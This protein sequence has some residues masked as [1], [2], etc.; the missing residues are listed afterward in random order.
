M[1]E[2]K[3]NDWIFSIIDNPNMTV[4]SFESVGLSSKN[5]S[6]ETEDKYKQVNEI[7]NHPMFQTNGA[8]DEGKFHQFYQNSLAGYSQLANDTFQDDLASA[9]SYYKD[10]IFA[11]TQRPEQMNK[12]LEAETSLLK[13]ANPFKHQI[14][15]QGLGSMVTSP[16]STSE[17]AQTHNILSNPE[18]VDFIKGDFSKAKWIESPNELAL[19]SNPVGYF[20]NLGNTQ[21]LAEWDNDGEHYDPLTHTTVQHKK[22]DFKYDENGNIF[23][24]NLNGRNIYGKKVLSKWDT[25]TVDGTSINSYDFF[26]SDDKQK[27]VKGTLLRSIFEVAPMFIPYV[28]TA[29]VGTRIAL[30]LSNLMATVGKMA[31]ES[32][33]LEVPFLADV[34][35][36][37]K[38][39]EFSTSEYSQNK[40]W[41]WENMINMATDVVTQLVEQRRMFEAI[42]KLQYMRKDALSEKHIGELRKGFMEEFMETNKAKGLEEFLTNPKLAQ[43]YADIKIKELT[44]VARSFGGELSRVYMTGITVADTYGDAIANGATP[45]EAALLTLGYAAGEYGILKTDIGNWILP[46]LK[47]EKQNMKQIVKTALAGPKL[48][49]ASNVAEKLSIGQRLLNFG[50]KV[51]QADYSG[52]KMTGEAVIANAL[53]EG[54]EETSEELLS[55]I[56]KQLG[57]WTI[58]PLFG[59]NTDFKPWEDISTRYAQSFLGG[60]LGGAVGQ[61]DPSYIAQTHAMTN[62]TYDQAIQQSVYLIGEGKGE[63]L[64]K[65]ASKLPLNNSYVSGLDQSERSLAAG[66]NSP[67][68][69]DQASKQMFNNFVD[70]TQDIL[71]SHGASIKAGTVLERNSDFLKKLR[72]EELANIHRGIKPEGSNTEQVSLT[73]Y[74]SFLQDFNTAR[75]ELVKKEFALK[76]LLHT[77]AIDSQKKEAAK[78]LDPAK[79]AQ[80]RLDVTKAAEEV[81]KYLEGKKTPE[82]VRFAIKEMSPIYM[83]PFE[84]VNEVI[85]VESYFGT[86]YDKLTPEQKSEGTVKWEEYKNSGVHKDRMRIAD[87]M[88]HKIAQML[89]PVLDDIQTNYFDKLDDDRFRI[90]QNVM[91]FQSRNLKSISD[92]ETLM[93]ALSKNPNFTPEVFD[94]QQEFFQRASAFTGV[95][96]EG[97]YQEQLSVDNPMHRLVAELA[98]FDPTI[99]VKIESLQDMIEKGQK[100]L[101]EAVKDYSNIVGESIYTN[102]DKIFTP[103]IS[104]GF[105]HP[106]MKPLALQALNNSIAYYE[107]MEIDKNTD[108]EGYNKQQ[109]ILTELKDTKREIQKLGSVPMLQILD[110]F[111]LSISEPTMTISQLMEQL[112]KLLEAPALSTVSIPKNLSTAIQQAEKVLQIYDSQLLGATTDEVGTINQDGNIGLDLFGV[113]ATVNQLE[114]KYGIPMEE[115]SNL[116]ELKGQ[117]A[118]QLREELKPIFNKIQFLRKLTELNSG[119]RISEQA[120]TAARAYHTMFSKFK[121]KL[122]GHDDL[123]DDTWNTDKDESGQGAL[124]RLKAAL[125]GL[126]ILNEMKAGEY[127]FEKEDR[128]KLEQ[129]RVKFEDAIYDFFQA[130][131]KKSYKDRAKVF[132][133]LNFADPENQLL[134]GD[135]GELSDAH[136][137]YWLMSRAVMKS[138]EFLNEYKNAFGNNSRIAPVV[139]QELGVHLAYATILKGDKMASWTKALADVIAEK[140]GNVPTYLDGIE[141][142]IGSSTDPYETSITP[143]FLRTV[144]IEGVPGS[145]KST[146]VASTIVAMLKA[147]HNDTLLKNVWVAHIGSDEA[148]ALSQDIGLEGAQVFDRTELLKLITGNTYDVDALKYTEDG[149]VDYGILPKRD[150]YYKMPMDYVDLEASKIP[151]II[152]ID[153]IG[154]FTSMELDMLDDFATK[155]GITVV[156]LGDLD[157]KKTI[158][159]GYSSQEQVD[160]ND[161]DLNEQLFR[162]NFIHAPKLGLS[163]RAD[164]NLKQDNQKWFQSSFDLLYNLKFSNETEFG[165]GVLK[166]FMDGGHPKLTFKYFENETGLFGERLINE[167]PGTSELSED[168]KES[169]VNMLRSRKPNKKGEIEKIG[170]T[171]TKRKV[172]DGTEDEIEAAQSNLYKFLKNGTFIDTDGIEKKIWDSIEIFENGRAQGKE[173]QYYI[174]EP[175]GSVLDKRSGDFWRDLYTGL[176]RSKQGSLI[177]IN[178]QAANILYNLDGTFGEDSVLENE[179]FYLTEQKVN[180][181]ISDPLNETIIQDAIDDRTEMLNGALLDE[182][183]LI[184]YEKPK[185]NKTVSSYVP[186]KRVKVFK[187]EGSRPFIAGKGFNVAKGRQFKNAAKTAGNKESFDLFSYSFATNETGFTETSNGYEPVSQ[188]AFENRVDGFNGLAKLFGY[189][190]YKLSQDQLTNLMTKLQQLREAA[191]YNDSYNNWHKRVSDILAGSSLPSDFKI[192]IGFKKGTNDGD[193]RLGNDISLEGLLNV[194]TTGSRTNQPQPNKISMFITTETEVDDGNGN[195]VKVEQPVQEVPLLLLPNYITL[196]TSSEITHTKDINGIPTETLNGLGNIWKEVHE[197]LKVTPEELKAM[198]PGEAKSTLEI[199]RQKMILERLEKASDITDS[200]KYIPGAQTLA[201]IVGLYTTLPGY[202]IYA[203]E[204]TTLTRDLQASGP[205]LNSRQKGRSNY[206]NAGFESDKGIKEYREIQEFANDQGLTISPV[207]ANFQEGGGIKTVGD[208]Q[209]QWVEPGKP[210]I[211]MTDRT[212]LSPEQLAEAYEEQL[213]EV[214]KK[215]AE[216]APEGTTMLDPNDYYAESLIPENRRIKLVYVIPPTATT[217][218]YAETLI[219]RLNN[220][221][222]DTIRPIGNDFTP[223]RI[224]ALQGMKDFTAPRDAKGDILPDT[225]RKAKNHAKVFELIE[226]LINL[227]KEYEQAEAAQDYEKMLNITQ[228]QLNIL[229]GDDFTAASKTK[230]DFRNKR[231]MQL[232]LANAFSNFASDGTKTRVINENR[233]QELVN[234][235][236]NDQNNVTYFYYNSIADLRDPEEIKGSFIKIKDL[237]KSFTVNG[238]LDTPVLFGNMTPLL[239]EFYGKVKDLAS[240]QGKHV[241]DTDMSQHPDTQAYL[242]KVV[243]SVSNLKTQGQ[244]FIETYPGRFSPE[245]ARAIES[246]FRTTGTTLTARSILNWAISENRGVIADLSNYDG[247][248][249]PIEDIYFIGAKDSNQ[250]AEWKALFSYT[251]PI[252]NAVHDIKIIQATLD[253]GQLTIDLNNVFSVYED[254]TPVT[255]LSTY[256]GDFEF[257]KDTISISRQITEEELDVELAKEGQNVGP[258]ITYNGTQREVEVIT[259][260]IQNAYLDEESPFKKGKF[261]KQFETIINGESSYTETLQF[262]NNCLNND[263]QRANLLTSLKKAK[264][265]YNPNNTDGLAILDTLIN[266]INGK[267]DERAKEELRNR[268][269]GPITLG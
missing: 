264:E 105:I 162:G 250:T 80:A 212:D 78:A 198:A 176:S 253:A 153:E 52:A 147:N 103:I 170:Y 58:S 202:V 2:S 22:G 64:K 195:M 224:L 23:Y 118:N 59:N 17:I 193:S 19:F 37:N 86:P 257:G 54:V 266:D 158:A 42:P 152:F 215:L 70:I 268:L 186:K 139:S 97:T 180:F 20:K 34:Q 137:A 146:G 182:V 89:K 190:P 209:F 53:G 51:A 127:D 14:G 259:N 141:G 68:D 69:L 18:D 63:E 230:S 7:R 189:D 134:N 66:K 65:I 104:Q 204:G 236:G 144:L 79:I 178:E 218:E 83:A 124:D 177:F 36:F 207:Y 241:H 115:R 210:F 166:T 265:K 93:A 10:D 40:S 74:A 256:K 109:Q 255:G 116:P 91:N 4:D 239:T 82:L 269:C 191:F 196:F 227:D 221:T 6:V 184:E 122:L 84:A 48:E 132:Q 261:K 11:P 3:E 243:T 61:L 175:D 260:A 167:V 31:T 44:K 222:S 164:N 151:S 200:S 197:E 106:E 16:F 72:I 145:G 233:L 172:Q 225:D 71:D 39:L 181:K 199:R 192:R 76:Q 41:T 62:M 219:E 119:T 171:Y 1:K 114:Q 229:K 185:A 226:K 251:D 94:Y 160:K 179:D 29:Y 223:F 136:F 244:Q 60:L 73:A 9:A 143:R 46:E 113:N 88:T 32:A 67:I 135:K 169:I 205:H 125:N 101:E 5:T 123:F 232:V 203:T 111:Q 56:V 213:D 249:M 92:P 157:Q 248:D 15:T 148:L 75:T 117:V 120:R 140:I 35:G 12:R 187:G 245:V 238:K 165:N 214:C 102:L 131:K 128:I 154:R 206:E 237:G 100:P 99:N 252:S 163:M 27:S 188:K 90:L 174:V 30:Q 267:V 216:G 112:N 26:D 121:T 161:P 149:K 201:A 33:G 211:L 110:N 242:G 220:P 47:A 87:Q 168:V 247:V 231:E 96:N 159:S 234:L 57:N 173:G 43:T 81:Q 240:K 25:L 129:E 107:G 77:D 13:V 130:N 45:Q 246:H 183:S 50:K 262:I 263:N 228:E 21:V 150:G 28:G 95:A 138:S 49:D 8:F 235:L 254:G 85:F 156:A 142:V 126:E 155:Y 258:I 98:E 217:K 38:A 108:T 24:E 55:D 208:I 194:H 133:N